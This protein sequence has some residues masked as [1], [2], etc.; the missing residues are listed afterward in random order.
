MCLPAAGQFIDHAA[1]WFSSATCRRGCVETFR[2]GPGLREQ[3]Y[4]RAM[5]RQTKSGPIRK[6]RP[7]PQLRE[8]YAREKKSINS[9]A[10]IGREKVRGN[11]EIKIYAELGWIRWRRWIYFKVNAWQFR[12][13]TVSL[14]S[15]RWNRTGGDERIKRQAAERKRE[16]LRYLSL[17]THKTTLKSQQILKNELQHRMHHSCTLTV[18][19]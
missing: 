6:S 2:S 3:I 1:L 11:R 7:R 12:W 8:T 9:H 18:D 17:G 14:S 5:S 16:L 19:P 10:R 15:R 4:D 13:N